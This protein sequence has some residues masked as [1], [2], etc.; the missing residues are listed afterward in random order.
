M[1]VERADITCRPAGMGPAA[2]GIAGR[3]AHGDG[4]HYDRF[5]DIK[6]HSTL[7]NQPFVL[8]AQA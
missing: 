8:G 5:P 4:F 7:A 1:Q 3:I 2:P 6:A